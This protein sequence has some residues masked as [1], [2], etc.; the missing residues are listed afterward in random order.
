M[1]RQ[2]AVLIAGGLVAV[3]AVVAALVVLTRPPG[4][5]VTA[6]FNEAV[7]V[8]PGSDLRIL[9]VKVGKVDAVT[10]I[11]HQ[12]KVTMTVDHGVKVPS[13]VNAVVVAPSVVADRFIQL[14]PPYTGGPQ[15]AGHA[16]IPAE[17]T[18]TPVELD[19]LYA[20][21]NQLM[22]QLGPNGV[23]ANGALSDVIKTGAANLGGNG[24]AFNNMIRQF[25]QLTKTLAGSKDDLFATLNNLQQ[26]TTMLKNNDGQ[27]RLA[28]Q[29]LASVNGFLAQ[30]REAL[31]AALNQLATAL[32]EVKKFIQDNRARLKTNVTKL[33]SIT[34][35]L[36]NQ[37]KSLAEVLD[38]VPLAADNVV[39]AYDPVHHTLVGRGNLNELSM[40]GPILLPDATESTA[41][42][43][44][45]VTTTKGACGQQTPDGKTAK[46]GPAP[47]PLPAVGNVYV[48]GGK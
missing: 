39:R 21:I 12:V 13:V 34:Q 10:P 25:G 4:K 19:Q 9:G 33:A 24:E 38:A 16:T 37:R 8:Y 1:S 44:C 29:Q 7:G 15:L 26:F 18:A 42:Q 2:R 40:G 41:S 11:G 27:V 31:A 5:R 23:N 43:V 3:L 35:V 36:V 45:A 17:R 14:T 30:D 28:E 47:L 20:S 46:D 6:Y 22:G 48:M 32:T